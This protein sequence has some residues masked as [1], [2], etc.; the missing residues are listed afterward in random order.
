MVDHELKGEKQMM[1]DKSQTWHYGLVA[2]YWAEHVTDGPEIAY[3]QKQIERNG[4]PA[5]D[6]GC[7]TGRLLLPF[8]R[9]GLDVDGC[10]VSPDMLALCQDKAELEGLKPRLYQQSLHE[11]AL[12]RMYQTIVACGVFGIGVSRQQ[13]SLA[14]QRFYQHL[15]S[16]GLLLLDHYLPYSNATEWQL[17]LK[18]RKELPEPW[19][20]T[21]GKTPP[22]KGSDYELYSRVIAFDPLEQQITRQM[23]TLL[24]QD[25]QLK[26]EAEYTLTENLYFRN[27]LCQLLERVGFEIEAVQGGYTEAEVTAEHE[28]MVFMARKKS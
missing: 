11:L 16:G 9:A 28:V 22:E 6:A 18:E 5:L 19:P 1:N 21:M 17:W 26:D 24:W 23:H 12:P 27:E 7:G 2:R 25:R 20:D 14:L 15:N 3:F 4:Q 13:D 8:L 10:D